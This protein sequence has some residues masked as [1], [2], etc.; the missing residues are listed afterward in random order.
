MNG[1]NFFKDKKIFYLLLNVDLKMN[2][3]FYFCDI[4]V[5]L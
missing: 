5:D 3:F 2:S 1:V 4:W